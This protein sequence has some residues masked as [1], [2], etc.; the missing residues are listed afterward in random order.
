MNSKKTAKSDKSNTIY[1]V[2]REAGV[3]IGTVS[4]ALNNS[5]YVNKKTRTKILGAVKKFDYMPNSV[6]RT[7]AKSS[8]NVIGIMVPEIGNHFL[9]AIMAN[10][11]SRIN[12]EGYSVLLCN[13]VYSPEKEVAFVKDLINRHASGLVMIS[14]ALDGSELPAHI[15][16]D[17]KMAGFESNITEIDSI[18][19][20][21]WQGAFDMT[22][23]LIS[24]GHRRIACVGVNTALL[25]VYDRYRGY[26]DALIKHGITP[27]NEYLVPYSEADLF[28]PRKMAFNLLELDEFPTA[29]FSINDHTA[30]GVYRAIRDKGLRVGT[31]ISVTGFDNTPIADIVNPGL[32][33]VGFDTNA[34]A[35]LLVEF[36]LKNI[37]GYDMYGPKEILFPTQLVLRDS[38]QKI[39]PDLV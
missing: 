34:I 7:L 2:A 12:R 17:L 23:H 18:R 1:D 6:A 9:A 22:E 32:S 16:A 10:I 21:N 15:W 30:I 26:R 25:T 8:D 19:L 36:L 38:S 4:R 39:N 3:S 14:S 37:R 33:S 29:M 11:E 35:E 31:D 20:T 24:L 28:D 5:G 27:R 13:S